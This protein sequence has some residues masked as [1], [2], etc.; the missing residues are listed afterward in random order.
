MVKLIDLNGILIRQFEPADA[1]GI[2]KLHK[3]V[4]WPISNKIFDYWL[5]YKKYSKVLV[6]V[7]DDIVAGK[8]TLDIAFPPYS[9]IVNLVIHPEFRRR[10]IGSRLVEKCL[11]IAEDHKCNIVYLMTEINNEPALKLYKKFNFLPIIIP[12]KKQDYIWLFRFSEENFIG[13]IISEILFPEFKLSRNR[14]KFYGGKAY[15]VQWKNPIKNEM[16]TLFIKGQPR[17]IGGVAP[18]ICGVNYR[19]KKFSLNIV[20]HEE[21]EYVGLEREAKCTVKIVNNGNAKFKLIKI[22]PILP[23]GLILV[24]NNLKEIRDIEIKPRDEINISLSYRMNESFDIPPLSFNTILSSLF[25]YTDIRDKPL[26]VSAGFE[27]K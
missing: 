6:A 1:E 13:E 22:R 9:E 24:S 3:L 25:I 23:N 2:I 17:Q 19:T 18:R 14:V 4:G 16:L 10:G 15:R 8:V 21:D 27:K 26:I 20:V 5:K 7:I 11:E 12:K